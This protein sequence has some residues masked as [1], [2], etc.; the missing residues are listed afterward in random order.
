MTTPGGGIPLSSRSAGK[1]GAERPAFT[2]AAFAS[3]LGSDQANPMLLK[4]WLRFSEFTITPRSEAYALFH[5]AV[6]MHGLGEHGYAKLVQAQ[7]PSMV[8][9][10]SRKI[11]FDDLLGTQSRD[12]SWVLRD[13]NTNPVFG[14]AISLITLQLDNGHV[15]IF[16]SKKE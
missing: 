11:F 7:N 8:W 3:T 16:R 12:G 9:S 1:A 14:T 5:Y 10:K 6:A 13:W 15:P 2:I 4:K